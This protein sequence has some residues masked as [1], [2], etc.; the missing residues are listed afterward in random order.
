[1]TVNENKENTSILEWG[2]LFLNWTEEK[3]YSTMVRLWEE[4]NLNKFLDVKKDEQCEKIADDEYRSFVEDFNVRDH[5]VVTL[6]H[7]KFIQKS[8]A[9]FKHFFES[10]HLKQEQ[11]EKHDDSKLT[12]F[13]EIVGYTQRWIWNKNTDAWKDAWKHHYTTNSHHPEYYQCLLG[14]GEITQTDMNDLDIAESVIDMLACRWERK[15][16]GKEDVEKRDLLDI[17]EFYLKRYTDR[18]RVKVKNILKQ[19]MESPDG[20]N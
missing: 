12:S 11:I 14:N 9:R 3:Q 8:F 2:K 1:M 13:L 18:D 16:N 5:F 6:N 4:F 7:K 20:T 17:E 15:L 10:I 19:L